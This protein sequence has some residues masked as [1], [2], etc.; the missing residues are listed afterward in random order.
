MFGQKRTCIQDVVNESRMYLFLTVNRKFYCVLKLSKSLDHLRQNITNSFLAVAD[1]GAKENVERGILDHLPWVTSPWFICA[2]ALG[3]K[4]GVNDII[5]EKIGRT[6]AYCQEKL[7]SSIP[8]DSG[9][10]FSQ[11]PN[12]EY[13]I[14]WWLSLSSRRLIKWHSVRPVPLNLQMRTYQ[15][16]WCLFSDSCKVYGRVGNQSLGLR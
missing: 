3:R 1:E 2:S 16:L 5:L 10:A 15:T 8:S 4:A 6:A 14:G 13:L 12:N 9:K 11:L 7:N